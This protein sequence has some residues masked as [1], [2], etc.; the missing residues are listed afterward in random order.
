MSL[1][2][3]QCTPAPDSSGIAATSAAA[4]QV[5]AAGNVNV[6]NFPGRMPGC[7][8]FIDI[9]QTSKKV[10]FVGT[11]AS[12]GLKVAVEGGQLRI[13]QEG[14]NRKFTAAVNEKTFAGSTVNGRTVLIIT[15]RAVFRLVKVRAAAVL[16]YWWPWWP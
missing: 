6:S 3:W 11:F 1:L 14:R 12:G 10:C 9:S 15:E 13:R 7:G 16:I 4:L 8:G 5:D 2:P